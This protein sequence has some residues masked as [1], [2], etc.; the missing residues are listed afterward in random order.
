MEVSRS[1][2]AFRSCSFSGLDAGKL[3]RYIERSILR[4]LCR[5]S[6]SFMKRSFCTR[7]QLDTRRLLLSA[8]F[9]FLPPREKSIYPLYYYSNDC[10][11]LT[12]KLEAAN[13]LLAETL[14][15]AVVCA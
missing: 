8:S 14:V 11:R 5:V 4:E 6:S 2:V 12:P 7:D 13:L 3:F 10:L 1:T 15:E 9:I